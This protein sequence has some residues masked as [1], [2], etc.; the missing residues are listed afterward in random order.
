MTSNRASRP[1]SQ[2]QFGGSCDPS[3]LRRPK[4]FEC[5]R[6][7]APQLD[8]NEHNSTPPTCDDI[9]LACR[10]PE[11]AGQDAVGPQSQVQRTNP[12]GKASR[13]L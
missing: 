5:V 13:T 12:F 2:K 6:E 10:S 1:A 9:D 3:P 7:R 8:F 11:I 4:R